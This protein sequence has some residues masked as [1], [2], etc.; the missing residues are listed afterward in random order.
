MWMRRDELL[1]GHLVSNTSR[2]TAA[3]ITVSARL[4]VRARA[5]ASV[6]QPS[7]GHAPPGSPDQHLFG[8]ANPHHEGPDHER[9]DPG[10]HVRKCVL[11]HRTPD[12]YAKGWLK[13][14]SA[15]EADASI[16]AVLPLE[17]W[18]TRTQSRPVRFP[19]IRKTSR[20][21][22]CRSAR[23]TTDGVPFTRARRTTSHEEDSWLVIRL[24][25]EVVTRL[26]SSRTRYCARER[27]CSRP[28]RSRT[29]A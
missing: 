1:N 20:S 23:S 11:H 29:R 2:R 6:Q 4:R 13:T 21:C 22:E 16:R 3:V 12:A 14:S 9:G 19:H 27:D 5:V 15:F 26:P 10:V 25:V 7:A 17:R 18:V 28:A 8:S 24:W